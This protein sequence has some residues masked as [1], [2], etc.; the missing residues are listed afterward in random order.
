M[1]DL[2]NKLREGAAL[3]GVDLDDQAIDRLLR[4]LEML[5]KWNAVY[6]LTA[7][8]DRESWVTAHLLDSLS[9]VP[10]LQGE[11]FLDVGT[12]PGFPGLPAAIARPDTEWILLDSNQKKTAF[13]SQVA[14]ELKLTN[15]TVQQSRVEGFQPVAPFDGVV[16]RAFSDIGDFARLTAHLLQADGWLFAMKGRLSPEEMA[17]VD[18][19]RFRIRI[20]PLVVP[21]LAGERHLVLLQPVKFE[22]SARQ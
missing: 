21:G 2:A 8:R 13:A 12:G 11:R 15:V 14:A 5:E 1:T 4:L 18:P 10:H 20:E 16:S 19:V 17:H 22:E 7:L 6:N 3:L 9:L